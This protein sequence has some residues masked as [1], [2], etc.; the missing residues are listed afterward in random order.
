MPLALVCSSPPREEVQTG[1]AE[2]RD[3]FRVPKVGLIAGCMV[4]EGEI[5]RNDRVRVVRDGVVVF[6][7][8]FASMRRFKDDVK[9]VKSGYECGLGIEKFQTSRWAICSRPIR[10]SRSHVPSKGLR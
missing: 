4:T 9:S 8:V 3:T 6:D 10:S 2:V 1:I 7:G 5:E